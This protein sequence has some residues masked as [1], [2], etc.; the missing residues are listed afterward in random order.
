M[1]ATK[2]K[3]QKRGEDSVH[4]TLEE[5]LVMSTNL[6]LERG[7]SLTSQ[8]KDCV[9][10]LDYDA[11]CYVGQSS[12][13]GDESD[14]SDNEDTDEDEDYESNC[15]ICGSRNRTGFLDK[16]KRDVFCRNKKAYRRHRL[17]EAAKF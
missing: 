7:V 10:D 17:E 13:R 15:F 4:R 3:L 9:V 8:E 12:T 16:G 2:D 5:K 6:L 11:S 14:E 1:E